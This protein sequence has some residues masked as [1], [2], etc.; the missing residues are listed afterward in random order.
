MANLVFITLD[1]VFPDDTGGRKLSLGRILHEN[2]NTNKILVVHY[3]Y[4]KQPTAEAKAFFRSRGIDYISYEPNFCKNGIKRIV[5]FLESIW[6]REP[7]AYYNIK[8]DEGFEVFLK[9]QLKQFNPSFISLESIFLPLTICSGYDYDVNITFH[10]VESEFYRSLSYSETKFVKKT[11]FFIQSLLIKKIEN[12]IFNNNEKTK[13]TFLSDNDKQFYEDKYSCN[14]LTAIINHNYIY[15]P[16]KVVR[17]P[18]VKEPFFLFAGSLNFPANS[19]AIDCLL[20]NCKQDWN[21][22]PKIVITGSVDSA[23]LEYFSKYDNLE[24]MGRV[25][26]EKLV[27]LYSECLACISPII[28]GGGVKIKN[29]EAMQLGVPLIATQFSCIGLNTKNKDVYISE[30]NSSS[31]YAA[32]TNY[33]LMVNSKNELTEL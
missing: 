2:K 30:D 8:K 27:E 28:T 4:S 21:Q 19:Y 11:F 17:N 15:L 33:Y 16:N 25:S 22:I 20:D 26:E 12:R 24:I 32:M 9:N 14:L 5:K 6:K 23:K 13:K 1:N 29:I 18:N 10:N 7:E 3:N 31:F